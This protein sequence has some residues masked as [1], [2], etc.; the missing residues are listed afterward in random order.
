[1][2]RDAIAYVEAHRRPGELIGGDW[3]A[4]RVVQYYLGDSD[5]VLL[6]HGFTDAD[7]RELVPR[8]AWILLRA[9]HPSSG[10][11]THELEAAGAL[12]AYFTNRVAQPNYSINVY[13]YSGQSPEF[14]APAGG[15]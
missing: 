4:H 15:A 9:Y 8:P 10:D 2:W 1:L 3:A 12:Q 13:Y 7:M 6:P 11:R 14:D 5:A